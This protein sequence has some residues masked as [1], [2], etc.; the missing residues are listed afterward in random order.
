MFARNTKAKARLNVG[1]KTYV[2]PEEW[3]HQSSHKLA[4]SNYSKPFSE[5]HHVC[6]GPVSKF[7]FIEIIVTYQHQNE[8]FE[9]C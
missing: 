3:L 6:Y 2:H 5:M 1:L 7:H 8:P 4:E 9:K